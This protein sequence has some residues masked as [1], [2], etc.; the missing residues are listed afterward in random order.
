MKFL[1]RMYKNATGVVDTIRS[2][3]QC[4]WG[5]CKEQVDRD[6]LENILATT[7]TISTNTAGNKV[8]EKPVKS[9][10]SLF[11]FRSIES[12]NAFKFIITFFCSFLILLKTAKFTQ[13]WKKCNKLLKFHCVNSGWP[14]CPPLAENSAFLNI[15]PPFWKFSKDFLRLFG[16]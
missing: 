10:S 3:D 13:N 14:E 6:W 4:E 11:S 12:I 5:R 15:F 2:I 8:L 16:K 7:T 9:E 1:N